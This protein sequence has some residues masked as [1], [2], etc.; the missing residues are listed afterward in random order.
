[1]VR[2]YVE[3]IYMPAAKAGAEAGKMQAA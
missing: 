2:E 3:N 1:M